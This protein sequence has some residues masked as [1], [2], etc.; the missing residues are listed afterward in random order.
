MGDSF[1]A[2]KPLILIVE[3]DRPIMNFMKAALRDQHYRIADVGAGRDALAYAGAYTPDVVLLDLGLPDVDG[4]DVIKDLRSWSDVPIIVVSARGN[5][6]SK[7]EAL[8]H[9]AD[10]YLTKPFGAGELL[11][12]IRVALRHSSSS[13]NTSLSDSK[14]VV[15]IGPLEFDAE[16]RKV[17]HDGRPVQLTPIEFRLLRELVFHAGKV[18]THK[19]LIAKA[20]GPKQKVESHNLRVFMATLR[21]K[22]EDDPSRPTLIVTEVGV[23]YRLL[24]EWPATAIDSY[25]PT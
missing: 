17:R 22:L 7:V 12:R 2:P 6:R 14:G 4:I 25:D 15:S 20:W 3:D 23:G 8:D 21:R 24:D 9:G 10:D 19:H 18:L 5:E 16:R 13:P 1:N 11:A